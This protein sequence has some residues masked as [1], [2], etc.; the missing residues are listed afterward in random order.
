MGACGSTIDEGDS[1]NAALDR[2]LR[3]QQQTEQ[4]KLKFLLLG[5]GESGKS[6]LFKQMKILFT[7]QHGFTQTELEKGIRV[8]YNNILA[9][10]KIL[11]A[12][13]DAHTPAEDQEL[14]D[15][16]LQIDEDKDNID[17]E[18]GEKLKA[19]WEDAGVQSTWM[20]RSNIQVQD[21]LSWYMAEIDRIA[22]DDYKPS[23]QDLLRSR[24]RTS[25]IVEAE[26]VVNGVTIAMFDVGGQRNERK[27]WIHC[28]DNVTA[29]IF[30]AAISEYDQVL[31]EDQ[32]TNRQ[33]E[34][35]ALFQEMCQSKWFR[36]KSMLLFL[37]K[38]DLF[39]DK[40]QYVPF[41]V[42]DGPSPRNVDYDGPEVEPGTPSAE[43]GTPEFEEV[44][45]ATTSYLIAK[46]KEAG[47]TDT[48]GR[49]NLNRE[50]YVKITAATDTDQ[51][52]TVMTA[53][54]DI[55]LRDNLR[56]NGFY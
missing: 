40:L 54:K 5:A 12:A 18:M 26:F 25:G 42:V 27:K 41:K 48:P 45:K 30:V 1:K 10:I 9:N 2:E 33:D 28:F 6:T 50:I 47:N 56:T 29:V 31:F 49:I 20:Q 19:I 4:N 24:V 17:T 34:A 38:R 53:A 51:V 43:E 46:Y 13:C 15:E 16:I 35:I 55:V 36:E 14:A 32:S 8:V 3:R 22:A 21:S 37:N 39:R 44:Y 7:E 11:V 23:N 52:A